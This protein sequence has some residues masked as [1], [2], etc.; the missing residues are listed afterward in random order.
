MDKQNCY[1]KTF[2]SSFEMKIQF[3]FKWT[4]SLLL[5]QSWIPS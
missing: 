2:S 4:I 5:M 3:E 1:K